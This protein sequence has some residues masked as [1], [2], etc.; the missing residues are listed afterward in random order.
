MVA[1]DD[2]RFGDDAAKLRT[3][4]TA[5]V[6]IDDPRFAVVSAKGPLWR[7]LEEALLIPTAPCYNLM[8]YRVT[9]LGDTSIGLY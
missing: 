7:F 9:R 8:C 4:W 6:A 2:L 5:L 3:S 1:I